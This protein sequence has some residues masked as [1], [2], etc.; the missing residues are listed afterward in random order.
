[1]EA[2][3]SREHSQAEPGN[4]TD[5]TDETDEADEAGREL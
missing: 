3:A 1:M 4:E 2:G 5:E